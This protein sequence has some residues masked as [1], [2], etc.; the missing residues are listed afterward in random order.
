M[1][2]IQILFIFGAA[3]TLISCGI[4]TESYSSSPAERCQE[5]GFKSGTDA[6]ANCIGQETRNDKRL[7][8]QEGLA[9]KAA[10][11]AFWKD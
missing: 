11:D 6:F 5:Y 9:R 7:K 10:D 3:L 1:K 4:S 8:Q 2:Q